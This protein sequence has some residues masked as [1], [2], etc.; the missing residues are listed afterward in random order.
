MRVLL[1]SSASYAPPRGG[2]TH[3]N[4]AWLR[5]L[6]ARGHECEVVAGEEP[7]G[8]EVTPA[9]GAGASPRILCA[10]NPGAQRELLQARIRDWNPHVVLVSS[11]DLSHILLR[12][13]DR[14]APGRVVYIAHTPQ[15]FP[16]G[17]ESWNPDP[18]GAELVRRSAGVIAIGRHMAAYI[19]RAIGVRAHVIHPPVYGTGPFTRLAA[20]EFVTM[21]NPSAVKGISIFVE[22]ARALPTTPFAVLPG[23]ATNR[24]D[25][26]VLARLP[27]V[28][29]LEPVADIEQFLRRTR[30]LLMPSLWYE[31]FGL[32]VMEAM[33]RGLPVIASDSGGLSEAKQGTGFVIP[34]RAVER[35]ERVYDDRHMP[36]AIV[37]PQDATPWIESVAELTAG[38]EAWQRES[39][40]SFQAATA[41]VATEPA[42]ALEAL[43]L[44]IDPAP[45]VERP[46]AGV[47]AL[48]QEK[49]ALLLRRLHR[50]K[51]R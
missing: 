26:A 34:V 22:V 47:A 4:L 42:N 24:A 28:T 5:E 18:R 29:M 20:G 16:F 13:A 3:S 49:R 19:E 32:I 45:V 8:R 6:A 23:W 31:G 39:D 12:E 21:I 14:S 11:E 44:S 46:P 43:L 33:L 36:C 50:M 17:P 40:R 27:N 30:V 48:S 10:D 35:Y 9:V 2:S 15:F 1:A 37:P 25:H 38:G 41:F 7:A 51:Y